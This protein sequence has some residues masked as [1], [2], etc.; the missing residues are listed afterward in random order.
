MA[1][2]VVHITKDLGCLCSTVSGIQKCLSESVLSNIFLGPYN[3]YIHVYLLLHLPQNT[4]SCTSYVQYM[5]WSIHSLPPE[6][7]S[8]SHLTYTEVNPIANK[9][10]PSYDNSTTGYA[11]VDHQ[12]TQ[13]VK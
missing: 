2:M 1:L 3:Y 10:V 4:M 12:K 13:E 7:N 6:A 5:Y 11:I 8:K 9:P